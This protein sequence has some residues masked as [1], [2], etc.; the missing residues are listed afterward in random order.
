MLK[1][2]C[3]SSGAAT[4]VP[5]SFLA[6][7]VVRPAARWSV[8][9]EMKNMHR[10]V[11]SA[12]QRG[13]HGAPSCPR[14]TSGRKA[15][16]PRCSSHEHA[17]TS[18][19]TPEPSRSASG[20]LQTFQQLCQRA[21][22]PVGAG[23]AACVSGFALFPSTDGGSGSGGWFGNGSGGGDG[24]GGSGGDGFGQPGGS[25]SL[26]D[27]AADEAAE[28]SADLPSTEEDKPLPKRSW[29]DLITPSDDLEEGPSG[30]RAGTNR[31]VEVVIEGWPSVGAL[32]KQVSSTH[33]S[34]PHS[35]CG[36]DTAWRARTAG[37]SAQPWP[38]HWAPTRPAAAIMIACQECIVD[39]PSSVR[40]RVPALQRELQ[41]ML[42]V[43]EGHIF[44]YQDIVDD[45][46]KLET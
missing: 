35:C 16:N 38:A 42:S 37:C 19:V 18:G 23:S 39:V 40:V 12:Q 29:K 41:D 22:L 14:P 28:D 25:Q 21:V 45:R 46:R 4:S 6:A 20:L 15:V 8:C 3:A 32:P 17:S 1:A 27:I 30:Q 44:D 2:W 5:S 36:T 10:S 33:C 11:A 9:I 34:R 7:C 26:F 31:C 13:V 24:G 43:Q